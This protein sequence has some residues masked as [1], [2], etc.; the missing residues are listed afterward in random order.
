MS[1]CYTTEPVSQYYRKKCCHV[2]SNYNDHNLQNVLFYE[3]VCFWMTYA[4]ANISVCVAIFSLL[5]EYLNL[6][7][8]HAYTAD[9]GPFPT[10]CFTCNEPLR[11][12]FRLTNVKMNSWWQTV[13]WE[14]MSSLFDKIRFLSNKAFLILPSAR[15]HFGEYEEDIIC[16][17]IKS[18]CLFPR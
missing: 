11:S 8:M 10:T 15:I 6:T 12:C 9:C 16:T 5:L 13:R 17:K 2:A 1:S 3:G 14:Q 18:I 4:R 7:N